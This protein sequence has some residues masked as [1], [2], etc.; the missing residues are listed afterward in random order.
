MAEI[1]TIFNYKFND[2]ELENE[3]NNFFNKYDLNPLFTNEHRVSDITVTYVDARSIVNTDG[4][5]H[6]LFKEFKDYLLIAYNNKMYEDSILRILYQSRT[7]QGMANNI[8]KIM[9]FM[10]SE[11][12][13]EHKYNSWNIVWY[14]DRF[15]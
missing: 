11:I 1:F 15:Q 5:Y 10:D 3:F 6:K 7:I 12:L 14:A 8:K 4:K 9:E 13:N 2:E